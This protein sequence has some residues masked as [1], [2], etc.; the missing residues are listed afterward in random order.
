MREVDGQAITIAKRVGVLQRGLQ[1]YTLYR[2]ST[3][4]DDGTRVPP[5]VLK[6]REEVDELLLQIAKLLPAVS[7]NHREAI[8]AFCTPSSF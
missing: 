4:H 6:M 5:D 7:D 3:H 1:A 2:A 8:L